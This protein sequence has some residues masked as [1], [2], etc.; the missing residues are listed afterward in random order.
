M[1]KGCNAGRV[2]WLYQ[3]FLK[4]NAII[5]SDLDDDSIVVIW[6]A[7]TVPL[8]KIS[9]TEDHG[10]RLLVYPGSERHTPYFKT[11]EALLGGGVFA[12]FSFIAQCL[13]VRAG[14]V[15]GLVKEIERRSGAPYVD[16]VLRILP[17]GSGS[18]FSEYET[19]G[20]WIWRHHRDGIMVRERNRWLRNGAALFR[21]RLGAWPADALFRLLS[22]RYDYV[23]IEKWRRPVTLARILSYL[24][25]KLK[26]RN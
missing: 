9:F 18:E 19:I 11:I 15:R 23:A 7:D 5:D 24:S 3:Q 12:D 6:D 1:V 2:H 10:G 13:P 14:W 26:S 8:R 17:G 16:A 21:G 20:T 22:C 25:R 4:I